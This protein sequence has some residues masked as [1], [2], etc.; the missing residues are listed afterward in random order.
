MYK[1][2]GFGHIIH[3]I[4]LTNLADY[5]EGSAKITAG[6]ISHKNVTITFSAT[7]QGG[8]YNYI[9]QAYGEA[10][11]DEDYFAKVQGKHWK[12]VR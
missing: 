12:R 6:G 5:Q 3:M 2:T 9:V 4:N 7:R 11:F 1:G 8:G 10:S